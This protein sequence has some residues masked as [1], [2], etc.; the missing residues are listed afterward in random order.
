[1]AQ[2]SLSLTLESVGKHDI[3]AIKAALDA[4]AGVTSVSVNDRGRVAVDYDSTGVT[5]DDITRRLR[6]LG[7]QFRGM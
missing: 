2:E 7:Y 1:M 6:T 5:K 4:L 3:Q